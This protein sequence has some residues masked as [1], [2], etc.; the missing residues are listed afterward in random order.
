M[1]NGELA[2]NY[3]LRVILYSRDVFAHSFSRWGQQVKRRGCTATVD[4]FLCRSPDGPYR[5]ILDWFSLSRNLGFKIVFRNYSR[6]KCLKQLFLGDCF[7]NTIDF[8]HFKEPPNFVFNRSLS[9]VELEI[10]RL[11][12]AIEGSRSRTYVSDKLAEMLPGIEPKRIK[13]KGK[14]YEYI[15]E[16]LSPV[17]EQI[18]SIVP[19]EEM[20]S[21][22]A[23]YLVTSDDNAT[24]T[25]DSEQ[26]SVLSE[27]ISKSS[28]GIRA[29]E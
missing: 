25:L 5:A 24:D 12:N 22:E 13:C 10:Q 20:I 28:E 15:K 8:S 23:K 19:Q 11:F 21:F 6:S 1:I 14:T 16:K 27:S 9:N 7:D 4:A 2:K 3:K 29:S 26:L 18:N 17:I